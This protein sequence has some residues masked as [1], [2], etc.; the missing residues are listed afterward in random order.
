MYTMTAG[1]KGHCTTRGTIDLVYRLQGTWFVFHGASTGYGGNGFQT[2]SDGIT[3]SSL[4]A[5]VNSSTEEL[6]RSYLIEGNKITKMYPIDIDSDP[7]ITNQELYICEGTISG[8]DIIWDTPQLVIPANPLG[9]HNEWNY[10]NDLKRD[11]SGRIHFTGRHIDENNEIYEIYWMRALN[12]YDISAWESPFT[13]VSGSP[14]TNGVDGHENVQLEGDEVYVIAR[15]NSNIY[16]PGKPAKFYGR[17]FD[18]T[19][20]ETALTELGISDGIGGSDRRL[21]ALLDPNESKIH[22]VYIDNDRNLYHRTLSK[23]YNSADWTAP[24]LVAT[25]TFTCTMGIDTTVSPSRIALVYGNQRASNGGRW[26]TGELYLKWFDGQNWESNS[27]LISESG[28]IYN[29]FP[30][31]IRDVS[32]EI[33]VMY[34]KGHWSAILDENGSLDIMFTLISD[35]YPTPVELTSFSATSENGQVYLN[36][37]TSSETNN[38]CFEIER[39]LD[40]RNFDKIGFILGNGTVSVPQNYTFTDKN[41]SFGTYYYRL[42]QIDVNGT[43]KYSEIVKVTVLPPK[44]YDL[45][46]NSPNPFNPETKIR[47]QIPEE[48]WVSL[49]I[50]NMKGQVVRTLVAGKRKAGYNTEIW[51]GRNDR[52]ELMASGIYIYQITTNDFKK[53]K[54]MILS[55]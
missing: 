14:T 27:L 39:S 53:T 7:N 51:D 28:T 8:T 4:K 2:S 42:N 20:W 55:R 33:G 31:M 40:G 21:C 50:F 3:W 11:S 1:I 10:Y 38:Y 18:G 49:Y 15:T 29:W 23:P 24:V 5:G 32:G 34:L 30:N 16:V 22:L 17:H 46:Q 47:Y 41:L 6:A 19:N 45:Y 9:G 13:V 36:W 12:P 43:F 37:T 44:N 54:K 48:G 25:N 52:G 26:H 35:N